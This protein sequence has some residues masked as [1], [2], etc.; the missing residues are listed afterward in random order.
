MDNAYKTRIRE[1][2]D[3]ENIAHEISCTQAFMLSEKY[4]IPLPDL[5]HFCNSN[6]IKIRGCQMGCFR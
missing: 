4:D 2:L 6:Q 5:G 1:A 3:T